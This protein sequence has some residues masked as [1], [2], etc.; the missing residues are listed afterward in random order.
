VREAS[1]QESR[2]RAGRIAY[3]VI[4]RLS[5]NTADLSL[6]AALSMRFLRGST[7]SSI[8]FMREVP[9]APAG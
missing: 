1:L 8:Q 2:S 4:S 7:F 9:P 5:S 3:R 6:R